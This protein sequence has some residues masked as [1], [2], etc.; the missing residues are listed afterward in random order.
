MKPLFKK[1]LLILTA[2]VLCLSVW[3]CSG[4]ASESE[5]SSEPRGTKVIVD[6]SGQ[7]VE[8]PDEIRSIA[9][10]NWSYP[11][12]I[13]AVTGRTDMIQTMAPGSMEA[14][15]DSMFQVMNPGLE[16]LPTDCLDN[17]ASINFEEL[18]KVK[19]D[20]ILCYESV[21][22]EVGEQIRAIGAVPVIIK[23]GSFE[24]V[25]ESIRIIGELFGCKDRAERLIAYHKQVLSYL[26]QKTADLPAVSERP[27]VL[28][29]ARRTGGE[30]QVICPSHLGE[31]MVLLAGGRMATEELTNVGT[32]ANVS[33]EQIAAWNPD[34]IFLSN[35]DSLTPADFTEGNLEPEWSLVSAVQNN[36]VY[37]TPMGIYRWDTLGA[38]TPL[39]VLWMAKVLHP[40]VYTEYDFQDELRFF[41][42]DEMGYALSDAD[43]ALI[44]NSSVNLYLNFDDAI[45][46]KAA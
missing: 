22:Q 36:R 44:L 15:L 31:K 21:E 35:F 18:A 23:F 39:A 5:E 37:K 45:Y 11:A 7:E 29:L 19:P 26:D 10:T 8:V 24:D 33:M 1:G 3:G 14:Y 17:G 46:Q 30:Y 20:V 34:V 41:Y 2:G 28:Y 13:Y 40:S 9:A 12:L 4:P 25:Q 38:E 27:S 6:A 32:T 42:A 43:T 16:N